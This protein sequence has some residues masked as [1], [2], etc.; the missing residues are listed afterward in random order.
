MKDGFYVRLTKEEDQEM[1]LDIQRDL[2]G[3]GV[4]VSEYVREA[5]K[6]KYARDKKLKSV[7]K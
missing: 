1:K 5:V 7:G 2:V 3:T 4:S 6:E